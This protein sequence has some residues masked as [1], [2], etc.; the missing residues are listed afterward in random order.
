M[1]ASGLSAATKAGSFP[2]SG[3]FLRAG[4]SD[5]PSGALA[6]VYVAPFDLPAT[7]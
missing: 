2:R 4:E 3:K 5:H 1:K 6:V 7:R